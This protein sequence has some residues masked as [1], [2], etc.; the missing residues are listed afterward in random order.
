MLRWWW[1]SRISPWETM[2]QN[3]ST[4]TTIREA[5]RKS[6]LASGPNISLPPQQNLCKK[7]PLNT[8]VCLD[9]KWLT[10]THQKNT[11]GYP[12][13]NKVDF[14]VVTLNFNYDNGRS[15]HLNRKD[16]PIPS[17]DIYTI[18]KVYFRNLKSILAVQDVQTASNPVINCAHDIVPKHHIIWTNCN[19]F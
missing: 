9:K 10:H 12:F 7:M 15:W 8:Y 13:M 2:E 18:I 17:D 4:G 16:K 11:F 19:H 1:N 5:V 3:R 6:D 14:K